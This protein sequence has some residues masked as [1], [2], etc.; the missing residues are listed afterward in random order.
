VSLSTKFFAA[1]GRKYRLHLERLPVRDKPYARPLLGFQNRDHRNPRV[2]V[3][4]NVARPEVDP[5][6][7]LVESSLD[8]KI[9]AYWAGGEEV[10]EDLDNAM[11]RLGLRYT[12][13]ESIEEDA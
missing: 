8:N 13:F 4:I 10:Y 12:V 5:P 9:H 2:G 6:L 7:T 1:S 11:A 3:T